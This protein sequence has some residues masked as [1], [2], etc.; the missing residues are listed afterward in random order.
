MYEEVRKYKVEPQIIFQYLKKITSDSGFSLD[1]VAEITQRLNLS[2]G[3]SLFSYGEN[4]EIS[5]DREPDGGSRVYV[6]SKPKVWFN[7]TADGNNRRNVQ[8]IFE[9]IEELI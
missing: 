8:R 4:V 2:T 9:I 1:S 3:L 6:N 7:I 5:V